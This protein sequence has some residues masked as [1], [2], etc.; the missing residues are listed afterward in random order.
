M[1]TR[2]FSAKHHEI[3][4]AITQCAWC[5]AIRV[6][7]LY[8]RLP[9]MPLIL[10]MWRFHLPHLPAMVI[11]TTHGACPHCAERVNASVV[12]RHFEPETVT[13]KVA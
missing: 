13:V 12:R 8:L 4:V 2:M 1:S 3:W 5:R 7:S 9:R 11:A 6:G 10:W